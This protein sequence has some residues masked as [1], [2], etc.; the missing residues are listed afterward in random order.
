MKGNPLLLASSCPGG[1]AFAY[2]AEVFVASGKWG[3]LMHSDAFVEVISNWACPSFPSPLGSKIMD[4]SSLL[5][6]SLSAL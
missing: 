4:L 2:A 5:L 1:L 6:P 3:L